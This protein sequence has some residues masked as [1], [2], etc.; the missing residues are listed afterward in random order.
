MKLRIGWVTPFNNRTGVGTFSKAVTDAIP[1]KHAG[2][3]IDLTIIAPVVE[4][5]YPTHHRFVDIASA[6]PDSKFYSMF[7]VLIYN[8]G[9]NE[10]HHKALFDVLQNY[11]GIIICHDYVYQHFLAKIV[12]DG[13]SAFADL[14]ALFARY[15]EPESMRR[16]RQ[17]NITQTKGLHYAIWD[18]DL[19]GLDP[20]GA[21]LFQL[22]SA[23]IV[24]SAYAEAY[25]SPRFDGPVLQLGMPWD[26][27]PTA[28]R[29]VE[30]VGAQSRQTLVSFGHVQST[31]CIDDILLAIASKQVLRDEI[32]YVVAG[33]SG[34]TTYVDHLKNIV[35]EHNLERCVRFAL[36][37]SQD[38]LEILCAQ[39]DAFINLRF[40]NTEGSSVSLIEQL[41]TAKP[42]I[43]FNT[44][45]YAEIPH[46]AVIK[47]S[48]P[49][50]VD[51][52]AD[53]ILRLRH[54]RTG[55]AAMGERGRSY[56][57]RSSCR[58]YVGELL[59]FIIRHEALLRRRGNAHATCLID[60]E[61][62]GGVED[63][64]DERWAEALSTARTTFDLLNQGRFA[65]DPTLIADI[66]PNRIVD[67][68]QSAILRQGMNMRLT[69]ALQD[70]FRD[71]PDLYRASKVLQAAYEFGTQQNLE[72]AEYLPDIIPHGDLNFWRILAALDGDMLAS[73]AHGSF[74]GSL[75]A[76]TTDGTALQNLDDSFIRRLRL[77]EALE[78]RRS[79]DLRASPEDLISVIRWLRRRD[80]S[81]N[82]MVLQPV[83]VGQTISTGSPE[84]QQFVRVFGFFGTSKEHPW[85]GPEPGS[86]YVVPAPGAR[87]V[88]L[89]GELLH[90]GV[91]IKV[92]L[93]T[94]KGLDY[95]SRN[96]CRDNGSI[97]IDLPDIPAATSGLPLC[98]ILESQGCRSPASF[99]NSSDP[100]PLGF[101]MR[102]VA[103]Q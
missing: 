83:R 45:C 95:T 49:R 12:H 90:S 40:P 67:Y 73:V 94:E 11:P 21:P 97:E 59:D 75:P 80:L 86:I 17:S 100:R 79:E 72:D 10:E 68:A 3:Q 65:L 16:I 23:L 84:H 30:P 70:Y 61:C 57:M 18:S 93:A 55:L 8:I 44:G 91:S 101:L 15:G 88:I 31:K 5:L 51:A 29:H 92:S 4:G 19:C 62:L 76:P 82:R 22:G 81:D 37:L 69:Q 58:S 56:A 77:S 42:V 24:H 35:R 9:N 14:V 87:K 46:D 85:S 98:L 38:E 34:A 71:Q 20:M 89:F 64:A 102:Q 2:G 50:N 78:A 74:F 52:I 7:D 60:V 32:T 96:Y 26:Q 13:S 36:D 27:R 48:T 43:V 63:E 25:A 66:G 47:V 99:G 28:A 53:A 103:I 54:D 6:T 1:A 41:I 33:F 39:A